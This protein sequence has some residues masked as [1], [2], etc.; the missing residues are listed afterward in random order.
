MLG[1]IETG[2]KM[3]AM[4]EQHGGAHFGTGPF[5]GVRYGVDQLVVNRVALL[6][7]VQD[8]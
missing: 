5:N 1:Q 2:A 6:W 3:L 4:P 7:A 8:D